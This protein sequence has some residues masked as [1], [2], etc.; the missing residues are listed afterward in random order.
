LPNVDKHPA[1][2]KHAFTYDLYVLLII[3]LFMFADNNVE[4]APSPQAGK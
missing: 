2:I 1:Y 3:V 4:M